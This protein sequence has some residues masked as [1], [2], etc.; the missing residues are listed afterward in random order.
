MTIMAAE[1]IERLLRSGFPDAD[2]AVSDM[3]QDGKVLSARVISTRFQ[4]HSRIDQHR[5]V[6]S[7][8][9]PHIGTAIERMIIK[10]DVPA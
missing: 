2:V 1:D 6:Y 4:G 5:M 3:R 10:T 8:L 9:E 7:I